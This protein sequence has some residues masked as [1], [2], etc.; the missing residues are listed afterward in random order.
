MYWYN[1]INAKNLFKMP[2]THFKSQIWQD[3]QDSMATVIADLSESIK[4]IK[5]K[6]EKLKHG[7]TYSDSDPR[8][9][10]QDS[11]SEF[12]QDPSPWKRLRNDNN[13]VEEEEEG[14]VD[15]PL[16]PLRE[17]Q[18]AYLQSIFKSRLDNSSRKSKA[19]NSEL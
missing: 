13:N 12:G 4:A 5:D 18:N 11:I 17:E 3:E 19:T 8:T 16:V 6:L 7:A 1:F 9:S 10:T 15:S 14:E 2:N